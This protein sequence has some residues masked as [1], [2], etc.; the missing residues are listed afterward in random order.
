MLKTHKEWAILQEDQTKG[1]YIQLLICQQDNQCLAILLI[2]PCKGWLS[3]LTDIWDR[4][5]ITMDM[6]LNTQTQWITHKRNLL[7]HN[8]TSRFIHHRVQLLRENIQ[9]MSSTAW[10]INDSLKIF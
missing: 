10:G 5:M 4:V 6:D 9:Q 2:K 3:N 8:S 1:M 7:G